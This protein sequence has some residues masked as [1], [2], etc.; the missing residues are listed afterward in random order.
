MQEKWNG[1]DARWINPIQSDFSKINENQGL[2]WHLYRVRHVLCNSHLC[3]YHIAKTSAIH[4]MGEGGSVSEL[5]RHFGLWLLCCGVVLL[6]AGGSQQI[7]WEQAPWG[8]WD[9]DISRF[10]LILLMAEILH[11]LACCVWES[12]GFFPYHPLNFKVVF[13]W[14]VVQDFSEIPMFHVLDHHNVKIEGVRGNNSLSKVVQDFRHQ[15][16]HVPT[17]D[18]YYWNLLILSIFF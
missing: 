1:T 10:I 16:Y 13:T 7:R 6:P 11:R 9:L 8:E 17:E 14:R 18:H 12:S 5:G 15:P 3:W 4:C 2:P